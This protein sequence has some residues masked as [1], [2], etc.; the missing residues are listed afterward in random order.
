MELKDHCILLKDEKIVSYISPVL[1]NTKKNIYI[2][3]EEIQ[4]N[5]RL[6]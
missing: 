6:K 1:W 4:G 2:T 3:I 5:A